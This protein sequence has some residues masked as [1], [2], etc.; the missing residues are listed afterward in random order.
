MKQ[1]LVSKHGGPEEL[2]LV[3]APK[4]APGTGQALVKIAASGVNYIDVYFRTGLHKADLPL[5]LGNEASG[6]V[7]SIGA[8]V[9]V[10]KPGDRVGTMWIIDKGLKPGE[11]VV[12]EGVQKVG[13][14]MPVNPLPFAETK[15]R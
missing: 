5:I 14:G 2:K 15:D 12:A 3:D 9:T 10:V 13:H 1:I 7:E 8:G 4:P 6:I 11:R